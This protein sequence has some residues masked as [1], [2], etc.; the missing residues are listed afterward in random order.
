MLGR[1]LSVG[2]VGLLAICLLVMASPA[3]ADQSWSFDVR[4][5]GFPAAAA[6][7]A[8]TLE[9]ASAH[10]GVGPDA[11]FDA[12]VTLGAVPDET[13][14]AQLV[15]A[16]G[17][18]QDDDGCVIAWQLSVPTL[19][20]SGPAS[21]DGATITV[22]TGAAD[23]TGTPCG[24]V[25]VVGPDETVVDRL[26]E[27]A[28]QTAISDPGGHTRITQVRG[29]RVTP[30]RWST[31]W[32]QVRYRGAEADGVRSRGESRGTGVAVRGR[33]VRVG[34]G[35]GDR[36]WVPLRVKLR[37]DRSHRLRVS[38]PPFGFLAF[39]SGGSRT[40]WIRPAR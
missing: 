35:T 16:I 6:A 15:V 20:P 33:T 22:R 37:G 9:S 31:I 36:V 28:G 34:L 40:V 24:S 26:E 38:A 39:P 18:V 25:S 32:L 23:G 10:T 7:P 21:R 4:P 17:T 11:T 27:P 30:G 3:Q 14:A 5:D 2:T 1:T 29:L 8:Q 12:T 19:S 13:S